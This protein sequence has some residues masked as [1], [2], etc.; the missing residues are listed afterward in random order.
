MWLKLDQV[1]YPPMRIRLE[2]FMKPVCMEG[3]VILEI[4]V[5]NDWIE[6]RKDA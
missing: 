1:G 6:V 4:T 2:R 3:S 5:T